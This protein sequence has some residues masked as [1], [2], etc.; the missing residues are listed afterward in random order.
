MK[1]EIATIQDVPEI[2]ELQYKAFRPVA[3]EVN[4][5]DAPGLKESLEQAL[6]D[7]PKYMTLKM[8]SDEGKIVGSVRGRVEDGALYIGRLMVLPECQG[9]G[10]GK[11]LFREIQKRLPHNRVWLFTCGEVQRTVSFYEREGFR[12]FHTEHF[13]NNHTWISME[14]NCSD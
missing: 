5:L 6:E 7:F 11:I 8:L 14:K 13:E 2:L 9:R 3:A 10:Y 4:W 12:T 1:I